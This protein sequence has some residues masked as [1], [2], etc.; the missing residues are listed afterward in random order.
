MRRSAPV[1]RLFAAAAILSGAGCMQSVRYDPA[2]ATRAY[3]FSQPQARVI[4]AQVFNDGESVTIVNAT[5]ESFGPVDVWMNQ[6]YLHRL[7]TGLAAGAVT[8]IPLDEFWDLR[9]EGPFPGGLL[10][11]YPPT[12]VR[13]V[14]L[15]AAPDQPLIGLVS[16]PTERELDTVRVRDAS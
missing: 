8:T 4:E 5:T 14:Q 16:I 13:L 9:G 12:P 11:Y 6:R 2:K 10:R 1:L 3:P 15:Q 7:E